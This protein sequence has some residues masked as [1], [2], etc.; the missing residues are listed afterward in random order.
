MGIFKGG[1][2]AM[3]EKTFEQVQ[4]FE[5]EVM[6]VKGTMNKFGLMFIMLL[7]GA[8]FTWSMFYQAGAEKVM[9]W[10]W[11]SLIGG[12]IV[13][14]VIIFKKTWAPFLA[15]GYGLL[16]GLFLGAVSAFYDFAFADKYPSI[17]MHAVLLT[18]GCA[19][20][21]YVLYH[22]GVIKATNTFK[23]VIFTATAGIAFFYLISI[24]LRLFGIQMP[25][26]HDNG[27][28]GIGISL[29]I[30]AIAALNLVLDFDMMNEGAQQGAP[31][32]FEWYCAFGL[33]VTIVWLYLEILR[34]LGK[35]NSRD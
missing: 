14:L 30:V 26:L 12:F 8:S 29:F 4:H 13:S 15:L 24:V 27:P 17:I 19:A 6:T 18:F 1:N 28:I 33:M 7:G 23:K 32:Y 21:M 16:Q 2:P 5:G 11:G 20:A 31:K 35:L 9:P 10:M 3:S 34:L 22:T 25:F